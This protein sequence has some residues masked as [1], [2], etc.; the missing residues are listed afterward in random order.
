ML[1]CQSLAFKKATTD[2]KRPS[3]LACFGFVLLII[4]AL[5]VATIVFGARRQRNAKKKV[6]SDFMIATGAILLLP[7]LFGVSLTINIL[8]SSMAQYIPEVNS[9]YRQSKP[10][11][12]LVHQFDGTLLCQSSEVGSGDNTGADFYMAVF[13]ISHGDTLLQQ[14]MTIMEQAG[15]TIDSDTG[16]MPITKTSTFRTVNL[17]KGSGQPAPQIQL[18]IKQGSSVSSGCGEKPHTL[19]E[20]HVNFSVKARSY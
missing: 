11:L 5:P 17:I 9:A 18:Q 19:P 7:W 1:P 16:I 20:G 3:Q 8:C 6:L 10:V 4:F 15:Y 13:D 14:A 2:M 12:N